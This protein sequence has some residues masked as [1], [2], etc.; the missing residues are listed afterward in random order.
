M[1]TQLARWEQKVRRSDGCW[2]WTAQR[3]RGGYGVFRVSTQYRTT[4]HRAGYALLVGPVPPDM[5]VDHLCRNRGC[6]NPAHLEVVTPSENRRRCDI[7]SGAR[8]PNGRK[9][10]CPHG[11]AYAGD[12]LREY[13]SHRVCVTCARARSA[14][15]R[16][17]RRAA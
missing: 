7:A 13:P 8:L 9:T 1:A 14:A 2:E 16:V 10:H 4:A 15:W 17:A 6:V 11:H 5:E 3:T 12:N